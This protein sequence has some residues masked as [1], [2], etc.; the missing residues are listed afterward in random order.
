MIGR[1][2][3]VIII[4][5]SCSTSKDSFIAVEETDDSTLNKLEYH[6]L[7]LGDSYTI[8]ESVDPKSSFPKQLERSLEGSLNIKV[9]TKILARTGWRTDN[10]LDAIRT[11][12][13]RPSYDF[14]TLLIGVNNQYQGAS[15]SKYEIEFPELLDYAI[16]LAD[17]NRDKVLVVSI[18]DWGFT[19]FGQDRDQQTISSEIDEY[20]D[21]AKKTAE[22]S[23]VHFINITDITRE[24]LLRPELVASDGLHPSKEAYQLFVQR[25]APIISTK[26]KD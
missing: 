1:L 23:D 9:E 22:D 13:L 7:A 25:I 2:L 21:F 26:L 11:T 5:L 20:N 19:P 16:R 17:D 14:V 10:L 12:E 15:F 24:G 18:P 6:Y 4:F 8:G 3:A